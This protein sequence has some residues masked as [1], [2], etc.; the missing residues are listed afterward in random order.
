MK[1][2][3]LKVLYLFRGEHRKCGVKA[4]LEQLL[5]KKEGKAWRNLF[6]VELV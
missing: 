4:V 1:A 5:G 6:E 3:K 2:A